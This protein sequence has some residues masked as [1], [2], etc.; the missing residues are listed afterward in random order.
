MMGKFK[1]LFDNYMDN[2]G[3]KPLCECP[4]EVQLLAVGMWIGRN[5]TNKEYEEKQDRLYDLIAEYYEEE[6][7]EEAKS[8]KIRQ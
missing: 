2:H 7:G 4:M 3:D 1:K 6:L 8:T 5:A